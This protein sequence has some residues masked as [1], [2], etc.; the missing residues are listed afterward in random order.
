[1][2]ALLKNQTL[3]E[4]EREKEGGREGERKGGKD[5]REGRKGEIKIHH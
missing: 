3:E 2:S 5:G 1:M 4:R